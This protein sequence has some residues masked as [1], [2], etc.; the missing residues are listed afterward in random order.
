MLAVEGIDSVL[1]GMMACVP[2]IWLIICS[3]G[4]ALLYRE[5]QKLGRVCLP[6]FLNILIFAITGDLRCLKE[7]ILTFAFALFV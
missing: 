4:C 2:V 3:F 6:F 5:A 1:V 7:E